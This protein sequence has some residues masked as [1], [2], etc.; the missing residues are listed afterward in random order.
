MS[1]YNNHFLICWLCMHVGVLGISHKSAEI[2]CREQIIAAYRVSKALLQ[3]SGWVLLATCSRMEIY[4]S[5]EDL[6]EAHSLLLNALRSELSFNVEHKLYAYFGLD[7]F[8]HLARV[9]AGLDSVILGESEIQRQVKEAYQFAARKKLPHDLHFLFQ[10]ALRLGKTIRTQFLFVEKNI[11]IDKELFL[12]AKYFKLHTSAILFI[13]F[14]EINR[15]II[16]YFQSKGMKQLFLCTRNRQAA[17]EW[18]KKED[19]LLLDFSQIELSSQFP[20]VVCGTYTN[21]PILHA[22]QFVDAKTR[23]IVDLSMPRAV[24]PFLSRHFS[25]SLLNI[26]QINAIIKTK[27]QK[28][29]LQIQ[30]A[31]TMLFQ[32]VQ[33]YL[34]VFQSSKRGYECVV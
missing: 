27:Q 14:S 11:G 16:S 25:V 31:E 21:Q 9:T 10:K 8:L 30:E 20:M 28:N 5:A 26:E 18:S 32:S 34:A 4:F 1:M 12:L 2:S 15:K 29:V 3:G 19:V 33:R 22:H 13:G 6:A 24:D 7:C 23:L 17:L